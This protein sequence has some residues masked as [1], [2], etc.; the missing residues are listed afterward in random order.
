MRQMIR[1]RR[2]SLLAGVGVVVAILL[3]ACGSASEA[4]SDEAVLAEMVSLGH[5]TLEPYYGQSDPAPYIRQFATDGTY[6]DPWTPGRLNGSAIEQHLMAFEGLIPLLRYEIVN[7]DVNVLGNTAVFTYNV[8]TYEPEGD[9][10]TSRWNAT[11]VRSRTDN[12]WQMVHAHWSPTEPGL[13]A[14]G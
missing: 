6:F 9:A 5:A 7:P 1:N 3:A 2:P 4:E 13:E 12:G 11:E 14:S 8:V 10:V